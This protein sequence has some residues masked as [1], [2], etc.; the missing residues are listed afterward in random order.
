M[1]A[2]R[3]PEQVRAMRM[4]AGLT[5]QACANRFGY[6]LRTWQSKEDAGSNGRSITRGEWEL[7]LLLAGQHPDF[8]LQLRTQ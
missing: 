1:S 7:L 6:S 4:A 8:I 5:Q 3:N 2:I